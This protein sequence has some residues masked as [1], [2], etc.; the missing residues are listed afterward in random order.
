M[1]TLTLLS[2]TTLSRTVEQMMLSLFR[3]YARW[4]AGGI[5]LVFIVTSLLPVLMG[6]GQ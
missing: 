3:Q 5:A 2:D 1:H 6:L 4:I